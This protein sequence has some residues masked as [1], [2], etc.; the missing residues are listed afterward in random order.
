VAAWKIQ[1]DVDLRVVLFAAGPFD[2]PFDSDGTDVTD[3]VRNQGITISRGRSDKFTSFQAGTCGLTLKNNN[4]E[5]DPSYPASPFAP[6][7]KP[8]RRLQVTAIYQG[9]PYVLFTGYVQ[10]WPRTWTKVSGDV[11]IVAHDAIGVMSRTTTGQSFG[12][13]IL[14]DPNRGRL[15]ANRLNGDLR[16]QMAGDRV[17]ALLQLA[18]FAAGANFEIDEGLTRI[19]AGDTPGNILNLIQEAETAEA[20]F[21]FVDREGV[22]RF[23]SRHARFLVDRLATVQATFTDC[24][25]ADLRVDHDLTQVWNDVTFT[26][27]DGGPQNVKDDASI[28]DYGVIAYDREIP[29]VSDGD[30]LG[31]AQFWRDRYSQPQDRPGPVLIRPRHNMAALFAA[32]AGSELLDRVEIE[33]TPLAVGDPV[34]FT[35]LVESIEHRITN[36]TWETALGISPVD[37]AD[38]DSFLRLDDP[39]LGELDADNLLAY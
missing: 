15:D 1:P 13:L 14:D 18:G 5:F 16:E 25:Y 36:Q 3:Y 32:V 33:R 20:G 23:L 38:V 22:I 29:V 9:T 6:L 10:G 8:L 35:G 26:R 12:S 4:R 30:A 39:S 17:G 7:L 27:P 11:T 19:V 2:N 21:F 37:L 31:R 34:T 28:H 24:D